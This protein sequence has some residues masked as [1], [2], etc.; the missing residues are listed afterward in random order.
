MPIFARFAGQTTT[1]RS[2]TRSRIS[3]VVKWLLAAG[4]LGYLVYIVDLDVL[5]STAAEARIVW[6]AAAVAL[7]PVNLFIEGTLWRR[8]TGLVMEPDPPRTNFAALL[9]GYAI[10]FLTPGRLGELA[11]R[12]FYHS[13][14]N[15]WELSAL[16]MFQRLIDMLVGVTIGL[17][18]V[19]LFAAT[20]NGHQD[21]LWLMIVAVGVISVALLAY[22][23]A[24]PGT[25]HDIL[26]GWIRRQSVLEPIRFLRRVKPVHVGPYLGL[27]TLRYTVFITQFVFLIFAFDPS[28]TV[29]ATYNG[30]AMTFYGKYL[31]PS[32]TIMDLGV[33]ESSAVF[34]MGAAGLSRAAAFNASLFMFAINL[35]IPSAAGIPFVMRLRLSRD[36]AIA[37]TGS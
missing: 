37:A 3:L 13:H 10:G 15:K 2:L 27:A 21:G 17:A 9:S 36:D 26:S 34:F 33:R 12:S 6:I 7:L 29:A 5:L 24:R 30:T 31:I 19:S 22:V 4:I 1:P 18:A 25:S 20:Q 16:V 32:V 14:A 28:A 23:L 35:V 11:G 8:I